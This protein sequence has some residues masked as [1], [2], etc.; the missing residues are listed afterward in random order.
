[1]GAPASAVAG[2]RAGAH[3]SVPAE[4]VGMHDAFGNQE[5]D[6]LM[7]LNSTR[8]DCRSCEE[9]HGSSV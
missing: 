7:A 1:M 6:E 5:F 3:P 4:F 9:A 2:R 8:G